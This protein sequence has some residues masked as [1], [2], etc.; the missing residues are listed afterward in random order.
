MKQYFIARQNVDWTNFLEKNHYPRST[1]YAKTDSLTNAKNVKNG[2]NQ[3]FEHRFQ[4][5]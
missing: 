1:T 4:D 3:D 5:N 2:Q